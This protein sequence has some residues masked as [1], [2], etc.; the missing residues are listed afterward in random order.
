MCWRRGVVPVYEDLWLTPEEWK[1][2]Q[3]VVKAAVAYCEGT[4]PDDHPL[5]EELR[6]AVGELTKE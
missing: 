1:K 6:R 5:D 3:A 2:L 4:N